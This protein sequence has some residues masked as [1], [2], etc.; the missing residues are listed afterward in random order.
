[1]AVRRSDLHRRLFA[2]AAGQGGFFSAAQAVEIGYSYQAQAHHVRAGNW[3]RVD[4]GLFHLVEWVPEIHDELARWALW[5]GGQGVV[6]HETALAVHGIGEFESP[7]VHLTVPPGFTRQHPALVLHH[8]VLPPDD[9]QG[10]AGFAVTN[11]VRTLVDIAV[12][13]PDPDHLA[14]AIGEAREA[15]LLTFRQLRTRA[16]EVDL[17]AALEIERALNHQSA[18]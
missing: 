15:G 5:S 14:R 16:D 17:R 6:S 3:L 9:V 7:S 13:R 2:L 18:P 11:P 12:G 10:Q 1:M 8:D 4:R